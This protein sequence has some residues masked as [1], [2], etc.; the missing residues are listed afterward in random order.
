V[1]IKEIS[2]IFSKIKRIFFTICCFKF[3]KI[4][5]KIFNNLKNLY[6][7]FKA[8]S[9]KTFARRHYPLLL[10]ILFL[11][12]SFVFLTL[13][14]NYHL[15]KKF[16]QA[17]PFTGAVRVSKG[18][19][20]LSTAG[21]WLKSMAFSGDGING[22]GDYFQPIH[23]GTRATTEGSAGSLAVGEVAM[24]P[25]VVNNYDAAGAV[26]IPWQPNANGNFYGVT[27][28]VMNANTSAAN[29]NV[30]VELV[31]FPSAS[32]S[33]TPPSV[34]WSNYVSCSAVNT[35]T[36]PTDTVIERSQVMRFDQSISGE[37]DYPGNYGIHYMDFRFDPPLPVTTSGHYGFRVYYNSLTTSATWP[38]NGTAAKPQVNA[39]N[40]GLGVADVDTANAST[41][42]IPLAQSINMVAINSA[43]AVGQSAAARTQNEHWNGV[44][45]SS[46]GNWTITGSVSGAQTAKLTSATNG[47]TGASWVNDGVNMTT[48]SSD[49]TATTKLCVNSIT[50]FAANQNID[51]WDSDTASIGRTILSTNGADGSCASSK[52]ITVTATLAATDTFTVSKN[53][54]VA[55]ANWKMRIIQGAEETV[56]QVIDTTHFCVADASQF[57][58]ATGGAS[59]INI[60]D[61][62]SIIAARQIT[63]IQPDTGCTVGT[64]DKITVNTS[65]AG[66]YTVAAH[67]HVAELSTNFSNSGTPSDGN[68]FRLTSLN[69]GQ[70]PAK[71]G[72]GNSFLLLY[73]K[74]AAPATSANN[75]PWLA[76][77]RHAFFVAYG[78]ADTSAPV[79][80]DMVIIGGGATDPD[81]NDS[82]NL[83]NDL[84][85]GNISP[86]TVTVDKNF[87]MPLI[88][89]G[90]TGSGIGNGLTTPATASNGGS[91]FVSMLLTT[92]A[93]LAVSNAA[94]QRYRLT[95]P[96]KI[97]LSSGAS[98]EL[99]S[100]TSPLPKTATVDL[101]EDSAGPTVST[102][103]TADSTINSYIDVTSTAGFYIG[104]VVMIKDSNSVPITRIIAAVTSATRLTFTAAMVTGYNVAQGATVSRGPGTDVPTGADRR[105]YVYSARAQ[106]ARVNMYSQ[107]S[108]DY[109]TPQADLAVDINGDIDTGYLGAQQTSAG[110]TWMDASGSLAGNWSALD[111]VSVA[112]GNSYAVNDNDSSVGM[113]A[114]DDASAFPT[115]TGVGTLG[116]N[117]DATYNPEQSEIGTIPL[118][119]I[120]NYN[121]TGSAFSSNYKTS[122]AWTIFS[123]GANT[124]NNDAVYFGDQGS[125]P[126]YA[127]EFNIGTAISAT[128]DR[129]WEYWNGSSWT[130]FTPKFG[131]KYVTRGANNYGIGEYCMPF[132][133][134]PTFP[135]NII[136]VTDTTTLFGPGQYVKIE[137]N[138]SPTI[139]RRISAVTAG[140]PAN[141]TFTEVIPSGYT[142]SQSAK[143]CISNGG[144]WM[145]MDPNSLFSQTGRT[146]VSWNSWDIPSAAKNTVNGVNAYWIR[147]RIS[148]FSSWT[149]SPV[150]QTTPVG[151][152][153]V[154]N[155]NSENLTVSNSVS[156]AK[157]SQL[158]TGASFDPNETWTLRYNDNSTSISSLKTTRWYE[159]QGT[160][161]GTAHRWKS[162]NPD[163]DSSAYYE[164][165]VTEAAATNWRTLNGD[166]SWTD[167]N[168]TAKVYLNQSSSATAQRVGIFL[169]QD[170]DDYGYA[171]YITRTGT[172][173]NPATET[174]GWY[175]TAAGTETAIGTPTTINAVESFKWHCL[176]AEV[177][178]T[179]LQAKFWSPVSEDAD[180]NGDANEPVNWTAPGTESEINQTAFTAGRFGLACDTSLCR[181][182]DVTVKNTAGTQTWFNDNFND[183]GCWHVIGSIHG[184][185]GCAYNSVP[186]T[187]SY[188]NFT[189]KHKGGVQSGETGTNAV[190]GPLNAPEEGD[191]IYI[192]PLE[193]GSSVGLDE[194]TGITTSDTKTKY[195]NW[196]F[197]YNSS[198]GKYDVAGS[199]SGSVGTATPGSTY[200]SPNGEVA[201]KIKS[202]TPSGARFGDRAAYFQ[203]SL[204]RG[205]GNFT[206]LNN[207]SSAIIIQP[208]WAVSG[209]AT[210]Y[211]IEG[212]NGLAAQKGTIDFWFKP[213]FSGSPDYMQY[214][215]DYAANNN[216][217]RILVRIMPNGTI[218]AAVGPAF[219]KTTNGI[220][221]TPFSATAGQWNHFRLAWED[222]DAGQ[223]N[224]K[225]AWLNGTAFTINQGT[226]VGA[227]GANAGYIRL[228]NSWQYNA[229]FD[230]AMD[231][232][233]I[234][235][236]A[237]DTA[238]SWGNFNGNLPSREW[239]NGE[240]AGTGSYTAQVSFLAHFN[241][242]LEEQKGFMNAD[243]FVG[244]PVMV[245]TN[246]VETL[247]NDR[248]RV[249]TYPKRTRIWTDNT[250]SQYTPAARVKYSEGYNPGTAPGAE[251]GWGTTF[252]YHHRAASHSTN[253]PITSPILNLR[254]QIRIWSDEDVNVANTTAP[255]NQGYGVLLYNPNAID[256]NNLEMSQL[257]YGLY[258]SGNPDTTVTPYST[259]YIRKCAFNNVQYNN[260]YTLSKTL[261]SQVIDNNNFSAQSVSYYPFREDTSANLTFS[262]N[263]VTGYSSGYFNYLNG[264]RIFTISG[265][266]FLNALYP[267]SL[268][269]GTA[270]VTLSNNEFWRFR[271]GISF[272][273]NSFITMSGNSFD[274][275]VSSESSNGY[276]GT[277]LYVAPSSSNV[278]VT[279]S[280]SVFGKS[281][282]NEADVSL[283]PDT[284][285]WLAG[286]LIRFI[287]NNTLFNSNFQYLGS[288]TQDKF[289]GEYLATAIPG[290]DF[291][292]SSG[293]DIVNYTNYGLMRTTGPGLVDTTVRTS[294]GYA[295][296]MESTSK[297]DPLEYT[298]QVVGVAGKPLAVTGYIRLNS[299]YGTANL[300]TVTLSGLGMTGTNLTWTAAATSDTWQQF[301]VSGTPT[302]SALA[303]V[304]VSIQ[305]QPVLA[306]SGTAE[307]IDDAQGINLP[308]IIEDTDKTWT[309]N[310]WVGYK[311]RD[312]QGFVFDI[313]GN[314]ANRLFLK[315]TRI[316]FS[317]ILPTQPYGGNYEI[318]SPPYVYLDDISVL[319]GTV[320]TGTL[321]FYSQ[322]QPVSPWLSTG[323]T[324]EGVWGTQYSSFSDIEGSFGQL[325]GDALVA[326]Y[327]EI[328]DPSSTVTSF[329]TNLTATDND[330]YNNG[331]IIFTE[332]NN[333]GIVRRMSDYNGGSKKV[334]VDPALPHAPSDGDKFAIL[335]ATATTGTTAA[336]VWS[337]VSR[338]LTDATLDTGNL[339][340]DT[341]VANIRSDIAALNDISASDVWAY[342]TKTITGV[343]ETGAKNIWDSAC[344]I[345]NTSGSVGKQ[346]CTNLDALVSSR[347]NI[348]AADVWGVGT[349]TIT[350]LSDSALSAVGAAVWNNGTKTLTNY[351]SDITA[352]EVWDTLT[353]SLTTIDSIGKLLVTNVDDI[354]SSRASQTSVDD[355]NT[356]TSNIDS[357]VDVS[358]S[359]RASQE[360]LNTFS[361][362]TAS[363]LSDISS[364][365][366][367]LSVNVAEI[368]GDL[369]SI[370]SKI[371]DIS[372]T[373]GTID[374]KI[375]TLDTN[376]DSIKLTVEDTNT[377]VSAI[378]IVT[379]NILGK[380]GTYSASD[381]AGYV[382]ALTDYVGT[383]DDD[384]SQETIFGRVKQ[385]KETVGSGGNV[386]LIST[387]V[388]AMSDKLSDV[389]LEL[390][391]NGKTTSAYDDIVAIKSYVNALQNGMASLDSE[392]ADVASSVNGVSSDLKTVTDKIGKV[393][394]D[395]FTQLFEVKKTDIEYLRN[396]II[397]LKAVADINRQLLE[398]TS[399]QPT[400]KVMMEWGSVIIKFVIVNPSN[401]IDQKIPFKAFLPKEVKQ[402]YIMDLG[403]LNLN[404]DTQ[405][406]Q[407]YV[408]SDINLKAGESVIRSVE[409]KDIWTISQD[410][411][412]SLKKQV[413]GIS[414]GLAN[415]S[416]NAQ[417][418]TLKTDI[419]TRL[420]RITR[421]QKDSTATPQDHILAYRENQEDMKAVQDNIKAENDL[422]INSGAGKSFLASV[423]GIQ[424]FAT[425]G[426]VL[427]L[428]FGMGALGFF[429]YALWRKKII[430]MGVQDIE[431]KEA[432]GDVSGDNKN[433][434]AQSQEENKMQSGQNIEIPTPSPF[435][436]VG[437]KFHWVKKAVIGLAILVKD[438]F[439]LLFIPLKFVYEK[440]SLHPKK[441]IAI[442][443]IIVLAAGGLGFF[444][445][446]KYQ[447]RNSSNKV[448]QETQQEV[449]DANNDKQQKI[450]QIVNDINQ[451][452]ETKSKIDQ[453]ISSQIKG[454]GEN[455]EKSNQEEAP[456]ENKLIIKSTPTG[457]LNVRENPA[458]DG[459]I[460]GKVYPKE[461]YAYSET[462]S[463]WY[464]ITLK[465]NQTGWI[466]GEY[467]ELQGDSSQKVTSNENKNALTIKETP[468][469]WL[470]V[471]EQPSIDSGLVGKVYPGEKYTYNE[472]GSGWYKI[473]LKD[474]KEGWVIGDYVNLEGNP[475]NVVGSNN[476]KEVLGAS[477][478]SSQE[479]VVRQSSLSAIDVY[480]NPSY[481][482]KI[483]ASVYPGESY[484]C[485]EN[486]GSWYKIILKDKKEGWVSGEYL[487]TKNGE[488]QA[489]AQWIKVI[490]KNGS[491][492]NI[493]E[494]PQISAKVIR[495][496][497]LTNSFKKLDE[498][499]EWIKIE[500][501]DG[502]AGW[503][504]KKFVN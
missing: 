481:T 138:D 72:A 110:N 178:G 133:A 289:G 262:N 135:T 32:Y 377:K 259:Q 188:L 326:K 300:P 327:A 283:A 290:V 364:D 91:G 386:D 186:F 233:A 457:W 397:E 69:M 266:K 468:T 8:N 96:G 340:T 466:N 160:S 109:R 484:E 380:W 456:K 134:D 272:N 304:K 403:G 20:T 68:T 237:I 7:E 437:E 314:T 208:T 280:G 241:S 339:A 130:A 402:E 346:V 320:D 154:E 391:F 303:T 103:L 370:D 475:E 149:T 407:Y 157:I 263:Y 185:Q 353:S 433:L 183:T 55:Q 374:S 22:D 124:E 162:P 215:F 189:I 472:T 354:I 126:V 1:K 76:N 40:F 298:A 247:A 498:N 491:Y 430:N 210:A 111:P 227:R 246:G 173:P 404:Y 485:T 129:V 220:L 429:Y 161:W 359:S 78:D 239:T 203:N 426:I 277:G 195:E 218:E 120:Y 411:V 232:F 116:L 226:A 11:I 371:D 143:I 85:L 257:Y 77:Q 336:D 459:N 136:Q 482:E 332:G 420:D 108:D 25:A 150:N 390:G 351:G 125:T 131:W 14:V 238:G 43:P 64:D 461:S 414:A 355:V 66:A 213:N 142:I 41:V 440:I 345:L 343:T 147:N 251:T 365:V 451:K 436:L 310:Q 423:G 158:S 410:E 405:T 244:Y 479:V 102:T 338:T 194:T 63:V 415:T 168:V 38:R 416:Y 323:L 98:L 452:A 329:N 75:Y 291:R 176:K 9:L 438:L 408:T 104:D 234:F 49:A 400:V 260:I 159:S 256:V 352:Q 401:S 460:I 417:A 155:E 249:V 446:K 223:S 36:Y 201:L 422:L 204:Q 487:R 169:R 65:L 478:N 483:I 166:F 254:K 503:V 372:T 264:G 107:G 447:S 171:A 212:N 278:E 180:C 463:G 79:D 388:Q 19:T 392:T 206:G 419:N 342:G 29:L 309:W 211:N 113:G 389:Q 449:K 181:F 140:A 379:S 57:S 307:N 396:K 2:K 265:N 33:G 5:V 285:S 465:D 284:T 202:G 432:G 439:K 179:T 148:N 409:I 205:V 421:K 219:G 431:K 45:S 350:G 337:Y 261:G 54:T 216:T 174:L 497:Y 325:L 83:S 112:Q 489:N 26:F 382:S 23:P 493:R 165:N 207:Q 114:N 301:V 282:W 82:T 357:K 441:A 153:G 496:V 229:G 286:S 225:R 486:Q 268:L 315:G 275:G 200:T 258:I 398:K 293:K 331:V 435:K 31:R 224:M 123:D 139:I 60:W 243:Y 17:A 167:Y 269:A 455:Q 312:N 182:D 276:Y 295:W 214:L 101:Y 477:L 81:A 287:G 191:E 221:S 453:E 412:D 324:A 156:E 27:L 296:R 333:K 387:Q 73:G 317:N 316:P 488:D 448:T 144:Q 367:D 356:K 30:V 368:Q 80:G 152:Q 122:S 361:E 318:Y 504:S 240:T 196:D 42:T 4:F 427:V 500:L 471:R 146:M 70:N 335:A 21:G 255:V 464:K 28:A 270:K 271:R 86:H 253:Q 48:L 61:D 328:D 137:D 424:T 39:I 499:N 373:L 334:T 187:S 52:S 193:R 418:I 231:E 217:D 394:T 74:T 47:G 443:I 6:K 490:P 313:I 378:Q 341:D 321:D 305:S 248:I 413:E 127:L 492:V 288:S 406:E 279:D 46:S 311:M 445:Y 100:S 50:G 95:A 37:T 376:I 13:F 198:S 44:Y 308:T 322:G 118:T 84:L 90:A 501:L 16:S 99:G 267:V 228:G 242:P 442:G 458:T 462:E 87:D 450:S 299:N 71:V 495:K 18:N 369:S 119:D 170:A 235:N 94:S 467:I 480:E 348:T 199:Q 347:S 222:S 67:A 34:T 209:S 302:D 360:S 12:P 330:Y 184:N 297:T 281:I 344:A 89:T 454:N 469:G 192:S 395:S 3:A 58:L 319:S 115:W 88:Y 252:Q 128:A 250:G 145:P 164:K 97:L 151:M 476:G 428:V 381:I 473:I 132:N 494:N 383:P 384:S 362:N 444:K 294:G 363:S 141:V 385:V 245:F 62:D 434:P 93:K 59:N 349:K 474:K 92:R 53:A 117:A 172:E 15:H 10:A 197:N 177:N 375:D 190:I 470:N 292:M 24:P 230:G 502:S 399:N 106:A 121:N 163:G 175:S 274:G 51:I 105:S 393:S 273:G 35:C 358:V 425:W 366:S 236:G 306:D 56:T